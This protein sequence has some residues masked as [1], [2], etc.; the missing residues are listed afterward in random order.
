MQ[1]TTE[2]VRKLAEHIVPVATNPEAFVFRTHGGGPWIGDEVVKNN[3]KPLLHR[4]GIKQ[5]IDG[6]GLHAFR[7]GNATLMDVER[8]PLKVGHD[9]LGHVDGE[10]ITLGI[11]THAE[12]DDRQAQQD[13][14]N[15]F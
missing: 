7:H 9:R 5:G 2:A 11:Y 10:E 6:V 14:A 13:I 8:I 15:S 3:L 1:Q 12:S 4:L